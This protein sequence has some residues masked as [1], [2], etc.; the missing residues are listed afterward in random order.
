LLLI[1]RDLEP[2]VEVIAD[3]IAQ[4]LE[5]RGHHDRRVRRGD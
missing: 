5:D 2:P 3:L 4:G 1:I